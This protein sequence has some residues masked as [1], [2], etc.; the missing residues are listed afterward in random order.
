MPTDILSEFSLAYTSV[1]PRI[2]PTVFTNYKPTTIPQF[3]PTELPSGITYISLSDRHTIQPSTY[4]PFDPIILPGKEPVNICSVLP[5]SAPPGNNI[6][7]L[8]MFT[9]VSKSQDTSHNP[10][11]V[12][13]FK[14]ID[15]TIPLIIKFPSE[16]PPKLSSIR[17]YC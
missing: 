12:S 7:F 10:S 17:S 1:F 4:P 14:P 3:Q 13:I 16:V 15:I 8:S 9:T 6:R 5:N 11:P 2:I